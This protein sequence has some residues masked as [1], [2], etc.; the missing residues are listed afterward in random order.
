LAFILFFPTMVAGPIKRYQDFEGKL[1]NPSK[2]W[3]EDWELGLTRILVGLAK[4]FAIADLLTAF[5]N[6]LN[7]ADISRAQRWV[8]PL[9]LLAYGFK[10]YFDFSA[11]SDIAI[12]SARLFGIK[13]P[14][15]FDWP[16][17]RTNITEFWAHW[18]MSL[19]KWLTD[20]IFIPLGGSRRAP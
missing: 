6:H 17:I 1:T 3:A 10:I 18:H 15:N 4:K 19:T 2:A 7:V 8:L 16:Y 14:E 5:T 13:V 11:Y 9:W 12:G 20:Y